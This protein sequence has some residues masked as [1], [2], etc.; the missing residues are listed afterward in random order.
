MSTSLSVKI[1][2]IMAAYNVERYIDE[3][4]Q[5]VLTQKE[6]SFELLIGDDASTD[7]TWAR[8]AGYPVD[9]RVRAWHFRKHKGAGI[10]RNRLIATAR[11]RYFSICDAD[12]VMLPGNLHRLSRM[13]DRQPFIG[14]VYGRILL[15]DSKGRPLPQRVSFPGPSKGWDLLRNLTPHPGTMLRRPLVERIG[16]YRSHFKVAEDYDL[17]L[18]L[19]E[20]AEFRFSKQRPT[21]CRRMHPNS[22]SRT[23][24]N[25]ATQIR[26]RR[27]AILRRY[28]VK[29]S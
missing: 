1:S 14:V 23:P 7:G 6:V 12:D 17:F 11:G 19:A 13:L 10:V 5:S 20:I 27:D 24:E 28:G 22:L 26:I 16:G 15:M 29:V 21:Y 4:I 8:I 9:S 3:A 2:V 25:K 18:R